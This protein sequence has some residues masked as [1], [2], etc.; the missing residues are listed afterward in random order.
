MIDTPIPVLAPDLFLRQLHPAAR[1]VP[2]R[3]LA[4]I[5]RREFDLPDDAVVR[6]PH[7]F[8]WNIA[9]DRVLSWFSVEELNFTGDTPDYLYLVAAPAIRPELLGETIPP[10][11]LTRCVYH[12]M[13]DHRIDGAFRADKVRPEQIRRFFRERGPAVMDEV[14]AVLDD[15]VRLSEEPSDRE[16]LREFASLFC[17]VYYFDADLLAAYLPGVVDPVGLEKQFQTWFGSADLFHELQPGGPTELPASPQE[18]KLPGIVAESEL[19]PVVSG[20]EADVLRQK[21]DVLSRSGNDVRAIH[22]LQAAGDH[23]QADETLHRLSARVAIAVREPTA[24]GEWFDLLRPAIIRIEADYW[25]RADRLLYDLQKACLD[26]EKTIYAVELPT[27]IVTLGRQKIKRPLERPREVRVLL[28]LRKATARIP[29]LELGL[30]D[31]KALTERMEAAA[32]ECETRI[33]AEFGPIL[34]Q[35]L[36]E[37]GLEPAGLTEVIAR[38][39]IV[40]E[41][42]DQIIANGYLRIG[43]LRD[44]LA[45]NRLK[46]EDL[47]S[48]GEWLG[49]DALLRAN[50]L[51]SERLDG[52]YRRGEIY[53][54]ALQR[55]S[56]L[57][58]GTRVGRFLTL[59][60]A[61]P[62]GGAFMLLEGVGH[63][64]EAGEGLYEFL[65]G[66]P[67]VPKSTVAASGAAGQLIVGLP[68]T[69]ANTWNILLMGMFLLLMI[70]IRPFRRA[71]GHV[72]WLAFVDLPRRVFR[73]PIVRGIFNNPATRFF[74]RHL[75]MPTLFAALFFVSARLFGGDDREAWISAAVGYLVPLVFFRTRIGRGIE[76]TVNDGIEL[77][78]RVV[79]LNFL[80]AIGRFLLAIFRGLLEGVE[81]AIYTVDEL[82]RFREGDSSISYVFKL[83]SGTV[84][85]LITYV[86]RFA[87]NLLI[88]PQINP[89]KHF[90]VVTVSHK[91]LLPLAPSLARQA[92]VETATMGIIVSG[93]PGIFGFLAWELK[94]NWKLYRANQ[95]PTLNPVAVGSHGEK[96]RSLLHP[97]FHSGAI[98]RTYGRLRKAVRRMRRS[99]DH[100]SL[101][102]HEHN[103]EHIGEAIHQMLEREMVTLLRSS[104]RWSARRIDAGVVQMSTNRVRLNLKIDDE[105]ITILIEDR[106][107]WLIASLENRGRYD[108]WPAPQ[109][110]A[111][112]DALM[113]V[114]KLCG[115]DLVREQ[116]AR[117][118]SPAA[119]HAE[120]TDEGLRIPIGEID[121]VFYPWSDSE[122]LRAVTAGGVEVPGEKPIARNLI[123]LSAVDLEWKTWTERWEADQ[124]GR[125]PANSLM[126]EWSIVGR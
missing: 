31:E 80:L 62:F 107:G 2:A 50:R 10:G 65:A 92:G 106:A 56:S 43:D 93:I 46:L 41:L 119:A 125:N 36:C 64:I 67:S 83:V 22:L 38:G 47:R 71:V 117:I 98:P 61:L 72:A 20:S 8:C 52:V 3:M 70:R 73:S 24:A 54:R 118:I 9:R 113:G 34:Q 88:E 105:T 14:R 40:A 28:A 58:F 104:R 91:L 84:W 12:A 121:S 27:W 87:L 18:V 11:H 114:Y 66:V 1:L 122:M 75:L 13:L 124:N 29:R 103:L 68:H 95:S 85:W 37:V 112:A 116:L 33:R 32:H 82:L 15:E 6:V 5:I 86:V 7:T 55:G 102:K 97:G 59:N 60:L 53:L 110:T 120:P 111:F 63:M 78:W 17:E 79:S 99:G 35:V 26:T 30:D 69:L 39:R 96:M 45:R 48:P 57:A 101:Y 51:L 16:L 4:R 123:L 126:Q 23:S 19:P 25:G 90:P 21:A 108:T 81:R 42:L 76:D 77:V 44:A 89:I 100:K 109:K 49:G 94:E 115:V 74:R